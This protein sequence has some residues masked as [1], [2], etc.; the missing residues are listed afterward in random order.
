MTT[1]DHST[2]GTLDGAGAE[3]ITV[4]LA[5]DQALLRAG[6]AMVIDSQQRMSVAAQ[7]GTGQEAL[8]LARIHRPDVVLMDIRMPQMD[9]LEA[10]AAITANPE[11]AEV[12]VIVLTTF[13]T[14]EYAL[15]ALRSGASGFLLKDVEPEVLLDSIRTVV[16]GGAVI[17]PTTTRRLLDATVLGGPDSGGR[18]RIPD[19]Q[20]QK[21]LALLTG[22]EHEILLEMA[23]GDSNTEIAARLY[24]SEATV[25]THV[26]QVLAKLGCRDRVQAVVFAYESGLVGH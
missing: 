25:K 26:G 22:R 7:A 13:D 20:Q 15:Q 6:F 23:T 18:R 12:K 21:R 1:T 5:D 11:L 8:D 17:A 14:D 9:G 10:T 24:L 19:A 3:N 16:S 4:L 2:D